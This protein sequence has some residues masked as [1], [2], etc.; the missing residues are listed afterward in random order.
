M[1]SREDEDVSDS[2][3]HVSGTKMF[4]AEDLIRDFRFPERR[5]TFGSAPNRTV[6]A[7]ID[8]TVFAEPLNGTQMSFVKHMNSKALS[9]TADLQRFNDTQASPRFRR[10]GLQTPQTDM[11]SLFWIVVLFVL[12]AN[13]KDRMPDRMTLRDSSRLF[14]SLQQRESG[15]IFEEVVQWANN[16]R[17]HKAS[18]NTYLAVLD[19][20]V[21][22]LILNLAIYFSIPW[23]NVRQQRVEDECHAHDV[24]QALLLPVI[25]KLSTND[26]E[27]D[28]PNPLPLVGAPTC[29]VG[30][31]SLSYPNTRQFSSTDMAKESSSSPTKKPR[32]DKVNPLAVLLETPTTLPYAQRTSMNDLLPS[33][34]GKAVS[35][36]TSSITVFSCK[37][38]LDCSPVVKTFENTRYLCGVMEKK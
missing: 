32:T 1:L 9:Y 15:R 26:V 16:I 36:G 29:A 17:N 33:R 28:G 19:R 2:E 3:N 24:F 8:P 5:A 10:K 20:S 11:E 31:Q 30:T 18:E 25:M 23:S 4:M 12:R 27:V 37:C 14:E 21:I 6:S 13:I 7:K 34:H 38:V 22:D 35:E